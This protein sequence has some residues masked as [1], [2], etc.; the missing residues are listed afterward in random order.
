[1]DI[2]LAFGRL[3]INEKGGY[4]GHKGIKSIIDA[5]GDE[6]IPRLRVGVGRSETGISASDHVLGR[7]SNNE[8][9]VLGQII[10][11]A[12]DAVVKILCNGITE[13]MNRFNEKKATTES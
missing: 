8:K 1:D 3:K 9:D 5:F 11:R 13:G 4:G 12:R 7:F 10:K 2:D 6:Y